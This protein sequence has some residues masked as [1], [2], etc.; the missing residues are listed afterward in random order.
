M[1]NAGN[2]AFYPSVGVA[3]LLIVLIGCKKDPPPEPDIFELPTG[4]G[5]FIINEGNFMWSN[6]TLDYLDI[7]ED[8]LYSQVYQSVHTDGLGDVFQSM[9]VQGDTAW[10]VV[11]NSGKLIAVDAVTLEKYAVIEGL[12][13]PRYVLPY[14]NI[15][16]ATDIYADQLSVIDIPSQ[17]VTASLPMGGWT[18]ELMKVND[19]V[20]VA[21]KG[22]DY[23]AVIDPKTITIVDSIAVNGGPTFLEEDQQGRIWLM[24]SGDGNSPPAL[25]VIDPDTKSIVK[26]FDFSP[27]IAPSN[28]S[29]NNAGTTLYYTYDGGVYRM[30]I[31]DNALPTQPLINISAQALY[32]MEVDPY[33]EDIWIMDAL[34]FAQPGQLIRYNNQGDSITSY[35]VGLIPNGM[36]FR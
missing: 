27:A 32:G 14:G 2:R 29:I 28:L 23:L 26:D 6:A 22:A 30:S 1:L 9:T 13:S 31:Q 33:Q 3:L 34:S 8:T 35:T 18:E 36:E 12:T 19:Q 20:W 17:S 15:V 4:R 25:L 16:F 7:E 24:C 10:L 11:N 21:V 5:A